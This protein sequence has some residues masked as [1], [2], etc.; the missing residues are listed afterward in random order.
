[1]QEPKKDWR[2]LAELVFDY[3]ARW[4]ERED[5][6]DDTSSDDYYD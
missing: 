5:G 4:Q 6:D 3:N 2:E 1:M